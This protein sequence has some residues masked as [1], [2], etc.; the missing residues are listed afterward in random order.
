MIAIVLTAGS[1]RRMRPLTDA[2]HKTLIE[3]G[4]R[5]VLDRILDALLE[6][7]VRRVVLVTGYRAEDLV[8]H[9]QKRKHEFEFEFVHNERWAQTNNV[10]SVA[11]ALEQARIDE[12]VLL[13]ESDLIVDKAVIA[14]VLQ[15]PY[16]D[17]AL[18]DHFRPGMDGTVLEL[19]GDVVRAVVP[20]HLQGP[21]FRIDDKYKTVNIYKFSQRFCTGAFRRLIS[22]YA[23]A[24][25][26]QCYYEVILGILVAGRKELMYAEVLHGESWCEIDDPVDLDQARFLFDPPSRSAMLAKTQGGMWLHDVLDFCWLRNMHFP[27]PSC[28]AELR[29]SVP[30]VLSSY[31]SAQMVLDR[32]MAYFLLCRPEQVVALSGASVLFPILTRLW[33]GRPILRP[34]PTFGEYARCFPWAN[35]YRDAPG[36]DPQILPERVPPGGVVVLVTPN[37]PSGFHIRA[38]DVHGLAE[39]WPDRFFLVDISFA[40]FSGDESLLTLLETKPLKN[41]AVLE[42]LSKSLGVPGLRLGWLYSD[43]EELL[44]AVRADVPVWAMGSLAEHFLEMLLKRRGEVAE[45]LL[46]TFQDREELTQLVSA[47]PGVQAV[48]P[49]AGNF[50]LVQLKGSANEAARFCVD[51]LRVHAV[52]LKDA[53]AKLADGHGWLRLAV[54]TPADHARL[55]TAWRTVYA[56]AKW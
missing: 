41:V 47:L 55:G 10:V 51:M 12:D 29:N 9:A 56:S 2:I 33:A 39:K 3:V 22:W 25:D 35:T 54:R 45:S 38:K 49:S 28:W 20:P 14:R 53:S 44:A 17:V 27:T 42:S 31:G 32:K 36:F 7:G 37:N 40:A 43:A 1:G 18:V 26:D 11:L 24:I 50:L 4:G 23:Q 21:D 46:R 16:P 8:Q 5:T 52:Y 30:L 19:E 6:N 34:E 48:V 13:I 15:S